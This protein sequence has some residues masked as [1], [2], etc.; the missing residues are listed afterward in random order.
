MNL[1]A[2]IQTAAA[3]AIGGAVTSTV[4]ALQNPAILSHPKQL[5]AIALAG[6][7]VGVGMLW[8]QRPAR[9]PKAPKK[10]AQ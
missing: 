7:A 3:A 4:D 10:A 6:A 5:G 2:L 1:K 9:K 8:K